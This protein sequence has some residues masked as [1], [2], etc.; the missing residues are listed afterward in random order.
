VSP[1]PVGSE[2]HQILTF[3]EQNPVSDGVGPYVTM[4]PVSENTETLIRKRLSPPKSTSFI[5]QCVGFR[6]MAYRDS[7]GQWRDYFND[8]EI[9][10]EVTIISEA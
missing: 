4:E 5:V 8:D 1:A 10:G 3:I 9:A 6:C 7:K 2:C